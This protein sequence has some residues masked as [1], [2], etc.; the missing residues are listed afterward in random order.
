MYVSVVKISPEIS[1]KRLFVI[2][3]LVKMLGLAFQNPMAR[4]YATVIRVIREI[5]VRK[6]R[7]MVKI[8]LEAGN[9]RSMEMVSYVIVSM[10]ILVKNAK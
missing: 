6:H 5:T 4:L 10:A 3:V 7:A 2:Q 8:A 1:V 9:A